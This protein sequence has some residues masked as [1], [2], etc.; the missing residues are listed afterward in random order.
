MLVE[1]FIMKETSIPVFSGQF[2]NIY[3]SNGNKVTNGFQFVDLSVLASE[4]MFKILMCQC[5][6]QR[7]FEFNEE[8]M[9]NVLKISTAAV[10]RTIAILF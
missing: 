7:L 6:Y 3:D 4:K 9:Q 8:A 2:F 10:K 5:H 1:C